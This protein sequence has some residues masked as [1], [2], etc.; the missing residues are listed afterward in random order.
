MARWWIP[1]DVVLVTAL[2]HTATGK[3]AKNELRKTY[4]D[5]RL[6]ETED[7]S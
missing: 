3:L 2:P 7:G 5:Y 6:P 4:A 1:D